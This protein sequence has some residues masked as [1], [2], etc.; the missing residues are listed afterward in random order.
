MVGGKNGEGA[1]DLILDGFPEISGSFDVM[2]M[3]NFRLE[4]M[5]CLAQSTNS[6]SI[7]TAQDGDYLVL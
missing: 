3:D 2:G 7:V 6:Q 1:L 4:L 5:E